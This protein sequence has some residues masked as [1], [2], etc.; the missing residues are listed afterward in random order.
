MNCFSVLF[1][2]FFWRA[3]LFYFCRTFLYIYEEEEKKLRIKQ[4]DSDHKNATMNELLET[5]FF[6]RIIQSYHYFLRKI[7]N[8]NTNTH[9]IFLSIRGNF[10]ELFSNKNFRSNVQK[11]QVRDYVIWICIFIPCEFMGC[12]SVVIDT[13]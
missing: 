5:Y 2:Y 3:F 11:S 4:N 9:H 1:L 10:E 8:T 13:L 6:F 7:M 12:I